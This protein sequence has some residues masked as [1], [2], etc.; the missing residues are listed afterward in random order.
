MCDAFDTLW[1]QLQNELQQLAWQM[2]DAPVQSAI[3][4]PLPPVPRGQENEPILSIRPKPVVGQAAIDAALACYQDLHNRPEYS[5]KAARRTVGALW[6]SPAVASTNPKGISDAVE[7]INSTKLTMQNWIRLHAPDRTAR[8]NLIREVCPGVMTL[9]LYRQLRCL[10]HADVTKVHFSWQRK[11]ALVVPDKEALLK[12]IDTE[13]ERAQDKYL[14]PLAQ[15]KDQIHQ[16][17]AAALRVRRAVKVQPVANLFFKAAP[18]Q[19]VTAPMPL[20]VIQREEPVIKT[21]HSFDA[22]KPRKERAD[23]AESQILGT[24]NGTTIELV[25]K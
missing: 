7:R 8:T 23:R 6:Y 21:L 18:V 15:L 19:T 11:D 2:N 5:H 12:R 16:A 13:M 1:K 17:P 24:L 9:S 14:L 25:L 10:N 3:V 4:S 20:I 22:T